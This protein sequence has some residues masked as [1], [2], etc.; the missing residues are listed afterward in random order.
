M[1]LQASINL[2][3]WWTIIKVPSAKQASRVVYEPEKQLP[4]TTPASNAND[5]GK[6]NDG[7]QY[8][9]L[10][11]AGRYE[12]QWIV[13]IRVDLHGGK[14]KDT[15]QELWS[16]GNLITSKSVL[17]TCKAAKDLSSIQKTDIKILFASQYLLEDHV[18]TS[19]S[20]DKYDEDGIRGV[21]MVKL[22]KQHPRC[23]PKSLMYD[24]SIIVLQKPILPWLPTIGYTPV[25]L[26][27]STG[28]VRQSKLTHQLCYVASFGRKYNNPIKNQDKEPKKP[29]LF[30]FKVK[31]R[32]YVID[33]P[34]CNAA[35]NFMC[36]SANDDFCDQNPNSEY[37]SCFEVRAKVGS[38]CDHDRGAPVV[39]N[40]EFV[41]MVIR[42]ANYIHC[43]T[44]LH[45]PFYTLNLPSLE[46]YFKT[47]RPEE[48]SLGTSEL[49]HVQIFRIL[50]SPIIVY[51][52]HW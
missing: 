34:R 45:L 13:D 15:D 33:L 21:R 5:W 7:S 11:F 29:H 16:V 12:F 38:V 18:D 26:D 27:P 25:P 8:L 32:V 4:S 17:T 20:G 22:I 24:A 37:N 31:Y 40:D 28:M 46:I 14:E 41:G 2:Y 48:A 52:L 3:F 1:Q 43:N 50:F 36:D 49:R 23:S 35:L 9:G 51:L 47:D 42:G 39:C 6:K 10:L 30:N 19:I 44:I